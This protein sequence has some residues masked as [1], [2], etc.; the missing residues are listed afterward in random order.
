[1]RSDLFVICISTQYRDNRAS[2]ILADQARK[3]RIEMFFLTMQGDYFDSPPNRHEG[4]LAHL[5]Q[6]SIPVL[7]LFPSDGE[8]YHLMRDHLT[9]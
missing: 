9:S 7:Y 5:I 1:M 8:L 3:M 6:G 4:W 2:R